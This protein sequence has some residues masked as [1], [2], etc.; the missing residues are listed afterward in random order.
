MCDKEATKPNSE[1]MILCANK[2]ISLSFADLLTLK[3]GPEVLKAK[4]I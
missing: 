3:V 2:S 4:I 1:K